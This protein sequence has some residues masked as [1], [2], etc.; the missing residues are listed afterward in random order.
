MTDQK[1][2]SGIVVRR[3]V[4][5]DETLFEARVQG[6]PDL[7]EYADTAEEAHALA[8]DAIDTTAR[9]FAEKGR[10]MPA[11]LQAAD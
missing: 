9:I 3:L 7:A 8:V 4:L 6:L 10:P 1:K 5:D 11:G 2:A